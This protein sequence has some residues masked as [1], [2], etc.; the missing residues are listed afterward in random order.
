MGDKVQQHPQSR[1]PH[2]DADDTGHCCQQKGQLDI[3]K[4]ARSGN[5]AQ[6]AEDDQRGGGGGSCYQLGGTTPQTA[7]NRRHDGGVKPV[8]GVVAVPLRSENQPVYF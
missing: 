5:T 6:R 1:H 8:L 3:G 7:D 4:T 2:G